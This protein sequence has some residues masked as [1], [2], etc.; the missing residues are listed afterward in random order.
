MLVE[1]K[2]KWWFT[3]SLFDWISS[4]ILSSFSKNSSLAAEFDIALRKKMGKNEFDTI[5]STLS[6]NSSLP[7]ELDMALRKEREKISWLD[8][9]LLH[10]RSCISFVVK[11]EKKNSSGDQGKGR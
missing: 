1:R 3:L 6:R 7:E 9:E 4:T 10:E 8:K 2:R 5:L 11:S